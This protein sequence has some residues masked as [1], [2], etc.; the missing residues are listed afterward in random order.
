MVSL[1]NE[2]VNS[3][4]EAKMDAAKDLNKPQPDSPQSVRD[5]W[6][7][8]KY[9]K[10]LFVDHSWDGGGEIDQE[11]AVFLDSGNSTVYMIAVV[12]VLQEVPSTQAK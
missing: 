3:I 8:A 7:Q 10:K 6:I 5:A 12:H 9:V 11:G 1:G 4:Y 2:A